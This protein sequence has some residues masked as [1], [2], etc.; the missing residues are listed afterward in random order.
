M[1]ALRVLKRLAARRSSPLRALVLNK[2]SNEVDER[3][4]TRPSG[5]LDCPDL[6]VVPF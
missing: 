2:N 6:F 1:V 5:H 4:R 3:F